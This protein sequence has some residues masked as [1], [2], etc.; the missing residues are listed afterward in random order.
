[1][2]IIKCVR[3]SAYAS[4]LTLSFLNFLL[5]VSE[6]RG[7]IFL[8]KTRSSPWRGACKIFIQLQSRIRICIPQAA[9]TNNRS[10]LVAGFPYNPTRHNMGVYLVESWWLNGMVSSLVQTAGSSKANPPPW[11]T[12]W[13]HTLEPSRPRIHFRRR[14]YVSNFSFYYLSLILARRCRGICRVLPETWQDQEVPRFLAKILPCP[15]KDGEKWKVLSMVQCTEI[16]PAATLRW[17]LKSEYVE[18]KKKMNYLEYYD[19]Y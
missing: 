14:I 6:A 7:N 15:T 18:Y 3:A 16:S 8:E 17:C 1:V 11:K 19:Y 2:K 13:S 4:F 10:R 9:H 12:T 5:V